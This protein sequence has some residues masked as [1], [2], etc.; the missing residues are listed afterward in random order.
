MKSQWMCSHTLRKI[1]FPVLF[2]SFFSVSF[3]RYGSLSINDLQQSRGGTFSMISR[4]GQNVLNMHLEKEFM[5]HEVTIGAGLNIVFP[6]NKRPPGLSLIELNHIQYDNGIW[7]IR[8][9]QLSDETYGYGLVMDGYN[10]SPIS[11]Y[12]NMSNTGIKGYAKTFFPLGIYGMYTG[13]GVVGTRLTYELSKVSG[14]DSPLVLGL[15]YVQDN[16]GVLD[17]SS[18]RINKGAYGYS[19]DVGFKLIK[20]WM[21]AYIEVGGLSNKASAFTIGTKIDGGSIVDFRVEYRILGKDFIP[22]FFNASYEIAPVDIAGSLPET[23]GYFVGAAIRAKPV[24]VVSIGYEKYGNRAAAIRGALA[25]N[26][27]KGIT[28]VVAYEQTLLPAVRYKISGTF[29]Y[30]L[31]AITSLVTYYEQVGTNEASYTVAYKMNF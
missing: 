29:I 26:E 22:S 13:T 15:S 12:F 2:F 19:A 30:P 11:T 20:P 28:G 10:S 25:F 4:E 24:G 1:L 9:G 16:D 21:D 3:A 17:T 7:G 14:I 23:T 5:F 8:F 18:S 6:E 31:N 27:I